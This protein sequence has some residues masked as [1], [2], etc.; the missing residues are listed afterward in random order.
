M[1]CDNGD[2]AADMLNDMERRERDLFLA[3]VKRDGRT[4]LSYFRLDFGDFRPARAG[5]PSRRTPPFRR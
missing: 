4:A 3:Q 5:R 2:S 1:F